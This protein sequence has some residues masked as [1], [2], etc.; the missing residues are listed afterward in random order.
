MNQASVSPLKLVVKLAALATYLSLSL[1][2]CTTPSWS[3]GQVLGARVGG[4]QH[5]PEDGSRP[6]LHHILVLHSYHWGF[7]WT[8]QVMEGMRAVLDASGLPL[9]IHVEYMDTKRQPPAKIFPLLVPVLAAKYHDTTFDVILSSDNNALDFLLEH[10]DALFP[11]VPIVFCGINNYSDQLVASRANITGVAED[12]DLHALTNLILEL[13]PDADVIAVISDDTETGQINLQRMRAAMPAFADH[14]SF[15]ELNALAIPDLVQALQGLPAGAP[16]IY[17]SYLRDPQGQLLTVEQSSR[18]IASNA[19]GPVY[20]AWDFT[21]G[22]GFVGGIVVD[23]KSQGRAAA[24]MAVAILHGRPV[25]DL[26]VLRDSPNTPMFDARQLRRW[27]IHEAD[28]P[29]GRVLLNRQLSPYEQYQSVIW[30]VLIFILAQSLAIAALLINRA[31]RRRA[32]AALRVSEARWQSLVENVPGAVYRCEVAPPWRMSYMSESIEAICGRPA[33]DFMD[34]ALAYADIV[35]PEDLPDLE[36]QVA[37]AVAQ[38]RTYETEYRVRHADGSVRWVHEKGRAFYDERGEALYLDG[39]VLDITGRRQAEEQLA[40]ANRSLQEVNERLRAALQAKDVMIQNVSHEL[41]TP[42]SIIQGYIELLTSDVLGPLA[43]EQIQAL[44]TMDRQAQRLHF[45]VS[46]LL[47]LQTFEPGAL[48]QR[49]LDLGAWLERSLL[50]WRTRGAAQH[51]EITLEAEEG[52][53]TVYV[54]TN[55]LG[56]VIENLLDNAI[57]FSP[58][59]G[60]V[61]VRAA[62]ADEARTMVAVSVRDQGVGLAADQLECIFQRFYQVDGSMT[63][64]FGGLGIGLALC[65]EIIEGHGGRL[66]AE[67]AGLGHG[68]TFYFT[69][70]AARPGEGATQ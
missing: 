31:Q 25:T 18:L 52:L 11:N 19:R 10:G 17:L 1:V 27:G 29:P 38:R 45:M 67:S 16:L 39:V 26:P 59:G 41:R 65:R 37:E 20:T 46:R 53:P 32:L 35:L 49:P 55:Y 22:Y 3:D 33:R 28:L 15:V 48:Y 13:H 23:G 6:S 43:S 9:E 47:I 4:I 44:Q 62:V 34:G 56:Q 42:L 57:K 24:E 50:P 66:W 61:V 21:L 30:G 64:P 69:L 54:D 2:G 51:V 68:S 60:R 12:F 8:D 40:Q 70:P 58:N 7:A 36:K 63:R 14:T 5:Q